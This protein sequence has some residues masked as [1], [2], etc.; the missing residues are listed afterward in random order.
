VCFVGC[1]LEIQA[2]HFAN[3]VLTEQERQMLEAIQ[4]FFP[5]ASQL[6][7][8]PKLLLS[9]AVIAVALLMLAVI[10]G[11]Q[12]NKAVPPS[13]ELWPN[14]KSLEGFKRR[15]D[16]ISEKNAAL[17]KLVAQSDRYGIYVG[18]LATKLG[19]PRDEA[20]YRA[21]ELQNEGLVEVLSLTDLNV[22]LDPDVVKL[23][24]GNATQFIAAY[25]K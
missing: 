19:T 7:L 14:N 16:V 22:R 15:L 25:L 12:P 4:R 9:T 23:L 24:G 20:V 17:L 3:R 13:A 10:W 21:K 6:P 5:W 1:S 2:L 11:P 18:D 8:L